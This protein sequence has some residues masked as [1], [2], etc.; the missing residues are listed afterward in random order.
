MITSGSV[1]SKTENS[2]IA[3][4]VEQLTRLNQAGD[5]A[6]VEAALAGE[7]AEQGDELG[8]FPLCIREMLA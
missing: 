3:Q 1:L 2:A 8:A 6:G 7:F 4:A 5:E